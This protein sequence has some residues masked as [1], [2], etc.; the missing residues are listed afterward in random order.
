MASL[1]AFGREQAIRASNL[2]RSIDAQKLDQTNVRRQLENANNQAYQSVAVAPVPGRRPAPPVLQASQS[3]NALPFIAQGLQGA[4]SGL[5]NAGVFGQG[6]QDAG[7]GINTSS[8]VYQGSK[9][10]YG[11]GFDFN[12]S[13]FMLGGS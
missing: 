12:T 7:L 6:A 1:A 11:R 13:Q 9:S 3:T 4:F 10:T 8:G 5:S 2:T